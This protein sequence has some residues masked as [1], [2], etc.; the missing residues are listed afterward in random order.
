MFENTETPRLIRELPNGKLYAGNIIECNECKYTGVMETNIDLIFGNLVVMC[1][2]CSI[3]LGAFRETPG[4]T[5]QK[6]EVE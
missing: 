2:H 1:P 3:I 6:K 5:E 4:Q